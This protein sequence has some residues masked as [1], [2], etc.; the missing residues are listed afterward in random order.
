MPYAGFFIMRKVHAT[1]VKFEN[2][3]ESS[4]KQLTDEWV[5]W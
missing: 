5:V 2:I 1:M 4:T 3:P